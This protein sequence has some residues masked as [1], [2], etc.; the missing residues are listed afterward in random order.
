MDVM[1]WHAIARITVLSGV[2]RKI[3]KFGIE[4]FWG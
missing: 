3:T 2:G 1:K 4:K